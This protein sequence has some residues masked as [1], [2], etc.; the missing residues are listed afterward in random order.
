MATIDLGALGKPLFE[1]LPD[2]PKDKALI[3]DNHRHAINRL[4]I[5]SVLSRAEAKRAEERLV[6]MISRALIAEGE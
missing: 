5:H 1:Q 6:K 4:R 2:L 3:L